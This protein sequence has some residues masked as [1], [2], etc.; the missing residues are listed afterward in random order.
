MSST[1]EPVLQARHVARA[2]GAV[3]ALRDA[4]LDVLPG[5]V[6]ALVGDNGAGKSTLVSMVC[7]ADT[8]DEG[9]V[10]LE[11]QRVSF[12]SPQHAQDLGIGTVYQQLALAPDLDVVKNLYLGR[13]VRRDGPL[14]TM[15][16]M[17]DRAAMRT[18]AIE[19]LED[20]QIQIPSVR[21]P[22]GALSGGQRQAISLARA[23]MRARTVMILDEPTAALGV[24]QTEQVLALIRRLVER[25]LGILLVSHSMP[26]VFDVADRVTVLRQGRTVA[27]LG[28]ADTDAEEVVGYMTGAISEPDA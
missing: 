21:N 24:V 27:D 15:L 6:T 8:P 10:I 26:E 16:R 22:V 11:G 18:G 20:L 7:G 17:P 19:V 13:T 14:G 28:A 9:E 4:S 23:A 2:F 3:Q 5:K 12:R 1:A 25:G